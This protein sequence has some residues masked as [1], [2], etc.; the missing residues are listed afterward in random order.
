[1]GDRSSLKLYLIIPSGCLF[2]FGLGFA[3][4]IRRPVDRSCAAIHAAVASGLP[5]RKRASIACAAPDH[6]SKC[7]D[8]TPFYPKWPPDWGRSN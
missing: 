4:C 5:V 2:G 6:I 7:H 3:V 1:M 8:F